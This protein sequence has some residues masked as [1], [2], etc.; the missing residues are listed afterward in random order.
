MSDEAE[1]TGVAGW[2]VDLMETL[3]GPGA[4]L[5]IAAENLFPPIPSEVILPLAGFTASRGSFTIAEAIFWTTAGS[6]VGAFVLYTLGVLLGR[7]RLRVIWGWLPLVK[8]SDLDKTEAWFAR[9]GKKTV[10]FGRFIPIF[11]SLISIPAGIERM[12]PLIFGV[13]TLAGSLVWNTIFVMAGY[14]LGENWHRVEPYADW[15]QKVVI[16]AVLVFI[17]WWVVTRVRQLR[18]EKNAGV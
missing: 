10:L 18:R 5:A 2:A 12:P 13:L 14:L 8:M 6:V 11:R 17:C 9:H 7:D 15:F 16:V 4:G 1:L 3:G